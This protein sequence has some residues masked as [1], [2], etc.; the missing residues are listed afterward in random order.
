MAHAYAHLF[1]MPTTG[2]RF[3][4]VYGPWGRPD[5]AM[6]IFTKAIL[7]GQPIQLFNHGKMRR[8]FTY[9]DDVVEAVVRLID[10]PA[11]GTRHGRAT[12]RP[13][14]SAAPWR[15]YNI[16]N[17][18]P[19][20]VPDVVDLIEKSLGRT[21]QREMAADAARRRSRDLCRCR[22]PD[23]RRRL[24]ARRPR[25]KTAWRASSPGIASYH[26]V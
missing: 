5:M 16:G 24:Q 14:R 2:L 7:E 8:D 22:R 23:A 1:Q 12:R 18:Q 13:A 25:S 9:I 19:V 26:G 17:N 21:A 11:A 15:I 10:R 3:F 20:D 4:T 6:W